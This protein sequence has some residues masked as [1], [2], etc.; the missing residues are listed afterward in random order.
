MAVFYVFQGETYKIERKGNYVWS[1]QLDKNNHKNAGYET[2]RC[3]QKGDFIIHNS[4]GKIMAIS[5]AQSDCYVSNQPLELKSA[6]T[7]IQWDDSGYRVDTDYSEIDSPLDVTKFRDWLKANYKDGSAFTKL[8]RGK[9]QYMCKINEEHAVFLLNKA[10][11]IQK[12]DISKTKLNSVLID[13]LDEQK[14]EYDSIENEQIYEILDTL[15][16]VSEIPQW[17][18]ETAPQAVTKSSATGREIAKRSPKVAADSIVRAG[19]KCEIDANH[20]T[21]LRKNGTQYTEPHHLIPISKYKEF[22]ASLD[23]ME[24][25]IS[26]CCNCHNQLH[27][28]RFEDKIPKL[29]KLYNKRKDALKKAGITISF[30]QLLSYYK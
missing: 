29:K 12:N 9:Q 27:Y 30:E 23:V 2:M 4:N 18:G 8:G 20:V 1:P 6:K 26:L 7:S 25:I 5:I 15:T 13:I 24:N 21:F 19:Y 28:G 3:I 14:S 22:N 10:I 11:K 16:S 17:K